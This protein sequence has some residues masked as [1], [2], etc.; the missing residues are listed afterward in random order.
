MLSEKDEIYQDCTMTIGEVLEIIGVKR[1]F[2]VIGELHGGPQRFNRL[3]RSLGGISTQSLTDILRHLEHNGIIDRHVLPTA[4]V[5]VEYSL[6]EQGRK[7][8][9]VLN[10]M[11]KW[12][13]AWKKQRYDMEQASLSSSEE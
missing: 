8:E 9:H 12:G 11:H 13:Q 7:F 5:A 10:E 4:P 1:A 3:R 2:L 6:T